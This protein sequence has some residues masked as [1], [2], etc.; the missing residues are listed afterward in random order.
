MTVVDLLPYLERAQDPSPDS[1]SPTGQSAVV[2]LNAEAAMFDVLAE[3]IEGTAL[4][5]NDRDL[6]K[7]EEELHRRYA[8]HV[9]GKPAI[10]KLIR[11]ARNPRSA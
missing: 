8:S 3:T 6:S 5:W 2:A 4:G 11:L 7:L 1:T 10:R 9:G